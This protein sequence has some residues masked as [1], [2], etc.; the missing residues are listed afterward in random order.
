MEEELPLPLKKKKTQVTLMNKT[1][2]DKLLNP[3]LITLACCLMMAGRLYIYEMDLKFAKL[4]KIMLIIMMSF[5][6]NEDCTKDVAYN[7]NFQPFCS[8]CI[9]KYTV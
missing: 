1:G 2:K 8:F 3:L 6:K 5:Y 4:R 9:E 7:G